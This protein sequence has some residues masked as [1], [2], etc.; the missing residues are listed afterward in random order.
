ME[1]IETI[2]LNDQTIDIIDVIELPNGG[3]VYLDRRAYD[4]L[5]GQGT[6]FDRHKNTWSFDISFSGSTDKAQIEI[7]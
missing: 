7:R 6:S 1:F 4:T 2:S 5:D 3:K